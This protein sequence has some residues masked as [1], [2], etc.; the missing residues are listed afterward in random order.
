LRNP[1]SWQID[2]TRRGEL[3]IG[4]AMILPAVV[5]LCLFAFAPLGVAVFDSFRAFNPFTHRA[6]GFIGFANFAAVL[7]DPPFRS[8][9]V[10]TLIYI[11]LML[12]VVIPLALGLAIL[13]DKRMPG[14]A[15]ARGAIL[16]ALAA[17]EAVS[18]LIWNQMYQPDSGLFN[19]I[20]KGLSLP[21]Q[22][23][24]NSGW[25]AILSI[26]VMS[27]WKDVG[28]PMLI[29]LG[30]LQAISPT[31]YE[32]SSIDGAS[33]WRQFTRIT[34]PL[35]RPSIV[36][37]LFM[38]TLGAARLFTPVMILT[39]GGPNG[40]TEN[41]T[42][43]SYAQAFLFNSPGRASASVM[44]MLILL[45]IITLVQTRALRGRRGETA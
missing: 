38:V 35:L 11:V 24:L 37:S 7:G 13:L 41:L 23:F 21:A 10:V 19:A 33:R 36:L 30:G 40:Q 34:L 29:F 2:P 20:I 14:T 17:S 25:Q 42:Y 15:I 26:V 3:V 9:L 43:Y 12:M 4:P 6:G 27:A 39:Q 45:V 5:G 16:G 44:L 1:F 8:A 28:L 22:P 32:A 18:A 31:L